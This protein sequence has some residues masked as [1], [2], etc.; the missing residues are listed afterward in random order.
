AP[1]SVEFA[2]FFVMILTTS[3]DENTSLRARS[4]SASVSF[5]GHC[6]TDADTCR[7]RRVLQFSR[8]QRRLARR[9]RPLILAIRLEVSIP[10]PDTSSSTRP[11]LNIPIL[12]P[13]SS[14]I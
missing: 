12:D 11:N 9:H 6:D 1:C 8:D 4:S 13:N 3:C 10:P 7:I 14:G 2:A 5:G